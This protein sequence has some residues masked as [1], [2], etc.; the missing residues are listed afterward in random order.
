MS[1][2]V[3]VAVACTGRFPVTLLV[4]ND[5][6]GYRGSLLFLFPLQNTEFIKCYKLKM[7]WVDIF[8]GCSTNNPVYLS[9]L[10]R[11]FCFIY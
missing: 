9:L 7:P 1:E 4:C 11:F 5:S 2:Q 3:L 6:L 8:S 10:E